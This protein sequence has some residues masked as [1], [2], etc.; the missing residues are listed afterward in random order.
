MH[1]LKTYGSETT[2]NSVLF[3]GTTLHTGQFSDH[4]RVFK[5]G[6][7]EFV[8]S[9]NDQQAHPASIIQQQKMFLSKHTQLDRFNLQFIMQGNVLELLFEILWLNLKYHIILLESH[10][11]HLLQLAF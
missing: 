7:L 5:R 8:P 4:Y 6:V 10:S 9:W 3:Q 2:T 1:L 11:G